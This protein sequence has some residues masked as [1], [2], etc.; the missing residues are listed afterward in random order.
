[1]FWI[2]WALI[3]ALLASLGPP[4][5]ICFLVGLAFFLIWA[6]AAPDRG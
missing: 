6:L 1:M 3:L 5:I 2:F 4:A